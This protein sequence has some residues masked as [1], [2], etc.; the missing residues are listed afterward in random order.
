MDMILTGRAIDA[1]E[2]H[3]SGLVQRLID[4]DALAG[5]LAYAREFACHSLPVL[6][7]AREAVGR[8]LSTPLSEGLRIEADLSTLAFQT[9]DATEGMAAFIEKRK[10]K[11]SD[12]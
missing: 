7:F 6:G 3:R 1:E 2:A 12:S 10:A 8:A 9:R 11:F 4:G 5:A